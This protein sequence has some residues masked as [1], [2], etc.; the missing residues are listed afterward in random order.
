MCPCVGGETEMDE[1]RMSLN[2][3]GPTRLDDRMDEEHPFVISDMTFNSE[4]A[5]H[6]HCAHHCDSHGERTTLGTS[7]AIQETIE[8]EE[9]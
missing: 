1:E 7:D 2:A 8:E 4:Q 6:T 5:T 3:R 9:M